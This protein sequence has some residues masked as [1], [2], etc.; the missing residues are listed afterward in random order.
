M[1]AS[2]VDLQRFQ[3]GSGFSILDQCVSG[4][5]DMTTKIVKFTVWKKFLRCFKYLSL[6]SMID[7]QANGEAS[8]PQKRTSQLR[9]NK[10]LH[11]FFFW[12]I[13]AHLDPDQASHN[14][15]RS[16]RI[17]IHNNGLCA[18]GILPSCQSTF[19]TAN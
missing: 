17:Q 16:M 18:G 15:C 12:V 11:F 14:Q 6:C 4:S 13:F 8:S 1:S 10:F 7:V 19:L 3:C 9:N 2:V 5:R